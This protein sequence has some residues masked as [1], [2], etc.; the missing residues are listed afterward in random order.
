VMD[1]AIVTRPVREFGNLDSRVRER[2][3][4]VRDAS[5]KLT[6]V[7]RPDDGGNGV[8]T[9][10]SQRGPRRIAVSPAPT[11]TVTPTRR[12]STAA[13][14]CCAV[15]D[16]PARIH[17]LQGYHDG[18]RLVRHL[19]LHCAQSQQQWQAPKT[20]ESSES[21]A[22]P[23]ISTLLTSVGVAI[24]LVALLG[25]WVSPDVRAGFGLYQQSGI[26]IAS[27]LILMG[28]VVRSDVIVLGG[29]AS[30]VGVML[31]DHLGGTPTP[32]LGWKQQTLLM[33]AVVLVGV[34]LTIRLM[35]PSGAFTARLRAAV[36]S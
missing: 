6:G 33:A 2:G 29:M 26:A 9:G 12:E 35:L 27:I 13:T 30:F 20:V 14:R 5:V 3:R 8:G 16:R 10:V 25:D 4:V 28:M 24:G 17:V 1:G 19:C 7:V 36:R 34:A 32:G 22:R 18:E 11:P 23:R 21:R 15:C 31:L